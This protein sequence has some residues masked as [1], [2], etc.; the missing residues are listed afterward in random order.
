ME[1]IG[2]KVVWRSATTIRGVQSVMISLADKTVLLSVDNLD[3][4][5]QV[6]IIIFQL[7]SAHACI[8]LIRILYS[9][10]S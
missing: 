10:L 7:Y 4:V 3:L 6:S 1:Q 5:M 2:M 9:A 8:L